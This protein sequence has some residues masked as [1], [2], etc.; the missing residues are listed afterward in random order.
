MTPPGIPGEHSLPPEVEEVLAYRRAARSIVRDRRK[1][2][3][4]RLVALVRLTE[5]ARAEAALPDWCQRAVWE[6]AAGFIE[7]KTRPLP[8]SPD[9][10]EQACRALLAKRLVRCPTCQRPLPAEE[11]LDR[12]R[13]ERLAALRE[14]H[15]REQAVKG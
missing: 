12:W 14:V 9:P 1:A 7:G 11:T 15:L 10:V 13:S 3:A 5:K 2:R 6:E 8:L 4:D